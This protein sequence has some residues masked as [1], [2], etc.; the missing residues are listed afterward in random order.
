MS[1]D[2]CLRQSLLRQAVDGEDRSW[3]GNIIF[4]EQLD[5]T[6][7]FDQ[8]ECIMGDSQSTWTSH[9]ELLVSVAIG[10]CKGLLGVTKL[11]IRPFGLDGLLA[12]GT[13]ETLGGTVL[14][15]LP[16]VSSTTLEERSRFIGGSVVK[17]SAINALIHR[18]PRH[19]GRPQIHLA[20][21]N[22]V[23]KVCS[24]VEHEGMPHHQHI[25]GRKIVTSE[26]DSARSKVNLLELRIRKDVGLLQVASGRR[27]GRPPRLK[28]IGGSRDIDGP[29]LL[30]Q[31]GLDLGRIGGVVAVSDAEE[32]IVGADVLAEVVEDG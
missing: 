18:R 16:Y 20:L 31:L 17:G 9:G 13:G 3:H 6:T 12:V 2:A 29:A 27:A 23:L 24:G 8:L 25:D 21:T 7:E 26:A 4:Q 19:A 5:V 22:A 32:A 14:K 28:A 11:A 15:V 10:G 1:V 30:T